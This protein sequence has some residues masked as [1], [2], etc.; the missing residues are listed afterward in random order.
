MVYHYNPDKNNVPEGLL[1]QT[2]A[3]LTRIS[4]TAP[5]AHFSAPECIFSD[6]L[7]DFT[8][9][10]RQNLRVNI[11]MPGDPQKGILDFGTIEG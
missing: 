4:S 2:E 1:N 3:H 11:T 6:F 10:D 5:Q 8:F 9:A 7:E